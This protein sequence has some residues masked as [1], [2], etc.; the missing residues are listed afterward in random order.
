MI[1]KVRIKK[2][3]TVVVNAGKDKG[4][5]GKVTA[6]L[7]KDNKVLVEGA[8]IRTIHAKAKK[9]GQESG[10]IKREA[11]ISASN[12]NVFCSKCNKAVRLGM[13][14]LENGEKVRVCKKCGE[15]IK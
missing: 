8:N 9:Q 11:P 1:A 15:E 10:I 14:V 2:G 6:V 5:K 12:V 3:D 7:V 4:L 13:K